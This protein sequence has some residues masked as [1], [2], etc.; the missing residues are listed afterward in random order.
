MNMYF[1][2]IHLVITVDK[3]LRDVD[4]LKSIPNPNELFSHVL[5]KNDIPN[6]IKGLGE[7]VRRLILAWAGGK[8]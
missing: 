3:P 7:V 2:N 1:R 6:G 5:E 8:H 4:L